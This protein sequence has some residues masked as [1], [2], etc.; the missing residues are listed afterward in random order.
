M[1]GIA[2]RGI[3]LFWVNIALHVESYKKRAFSL[4]F[5]VDTEGYDFH[6]S[7]NIFWM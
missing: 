6:F 5:G 4:L 2:G 7:L 1:G 3:F